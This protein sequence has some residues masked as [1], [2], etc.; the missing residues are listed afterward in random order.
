MPSTSQ[1]ITQTSTKMGLCLSIW[2]V[3]SERVPRDSQTSALS[4]SVRSTSDFAWTSVPAR[5]TW[6]APVAA[7]HEMTACLCISLFIACGDVTVASWMNTLLPAWRSVKPSGQPG[8][9]QR[10]A[11]WVAQKQTHAGLL[12]R[13]Q[14]AGPDYRNEIDLRQIQ[15]FWLH[16]DTMRGVLKRNSDHTAIKVV[17]TGSG[18]S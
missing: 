12:S 6:L 16:G 7:H 2:R 5:N 9:E 14:E 1:H 8:Q 3:M 15:S 4:C 10:R 18:Q 13:S 11:V 17:Q